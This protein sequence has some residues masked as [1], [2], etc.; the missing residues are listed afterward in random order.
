MNDA[1]ELTRQLFALMEKDERTQIAIANEARVSINTVWNWRGK[2][3]KRG[4]SLQTF[5]RFLDVLGYEFKI[6]KKE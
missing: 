5:I 4:V 1:N 6:V 2:Y 3:Q